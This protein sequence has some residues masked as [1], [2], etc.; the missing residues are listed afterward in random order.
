MAA[1]ILQLAINLAKNHHVDCA[2]LP[3]SFLPKREN[4][5]GEMLDIKDGVILNE[6]LILSMIK[7]LL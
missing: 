6:T 4:P 7:D 2:K 5:Y 3:L 1:G